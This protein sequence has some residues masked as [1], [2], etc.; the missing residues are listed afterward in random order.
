M[1]LLLRALAHI[2]AETPSIQAAMKAGRRTQISVRVY[3][4]KE[5]RWVDLGPISRA[6]GTFTQ[7]FEQTLLA[8][9]KTVL[10]FRWKG[11]EIER[12]NY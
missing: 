7:L 12:P 5:D 9:A 4:A 10:R 1:S 3:R 2:L 6:G 8:G 11:K